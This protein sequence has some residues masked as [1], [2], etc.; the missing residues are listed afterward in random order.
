MS[1]EWLVL[2][3]AQGLTGNVLDALLPAFGSVA[4]LLAARPAAL[5]AAG[6]PE[7]LARALAAPEEARVAAGLEWLAGG[8][9]RH[10]VGW[11][12]PRYPALL[13]QVPAAPVALFVRGDP[14]CLA[15]PQLAIVGSR[16]A[17]AGGAETARAFA[18]HLA[19]CGIAITSGLALGIDAAAHRGALEAGGRTIAVLGTG[20]DGCYPR[21]HAALAESIAAG[22]ALVTEFLPGVPPLRE[23][24]P[25]RNRIISGLAAGTL[26]V[27]AGLQSGAL[28]TARRALEQGREVFAVPGSIHNPLAKGCHEL[29]RGGAKLVESADH[30]LEEIGGL[31]AAARARDA[32]RAPRAGADDAPGTASARDGDYA[33]LLDALGWDTLGVDALVGRSGLT[34]GEV[35]SMLLILELEGV[36]QPV[37]GGR[38]QRQKIGDQG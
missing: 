27:E 19:R 23:N 11:D 24:F 37:A 8:A 30:V 14:A 25:R 26:V 38:Y 31:L 1:R 10:L 36:V 3:D 18:A 9:D 12:D 17:T 35:S 15:L 5:A 2:A 6:V 7:G 21:A 20:P 4:A 16:N 32:E 28:V 29:I 22:G 13:R 34:A 33:R